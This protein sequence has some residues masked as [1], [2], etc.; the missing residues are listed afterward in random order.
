[1]QMDEESPEL[2]LGS[3]GTRLRHPGT[4]LRS[5]S[6]ESFTTSE[7]DIHSGSDWIGRVLNDQYRLEDRLGGGGMG[8]VYLARDLLAEANQDPDPFVAVKV[9]TAALR[10]DTDATR[11]LQ[12][13][14]RRAQQLSHENIVRVHYFGRDA[15]TYY[16]TMELLRGQSFDQLIRDNRSGFVMHAVMP[17]IE[18]LCRGLAYA[19]KEGIIHS[20][21]KPNNVFLTDN[22]VVKV[23]DFGIAV[24]LR[25]SGATGPETRY[26][27]RRLGALTPGYSAVELYLGL[28]PDPRD[29]I[30]SA[31]C[32]IYELLSGRHPYDHKEAP[33]ALEKKMKPA[34]IGGLTRQQNLALQGALALE[35]NARTPDIDEFLAQL[36]KPEALPPPLLKWAVIGA[37][38]L[39]VVVGAI[40]FIA[41]P[42]GKQSA[43]SEVTASPTLPAEP[44]VVRKHYDVPDPQS[45]VES[46]PAISRR[47]PSALAPAEHPPVSTARDIARPANSQCSELDERWDR[48]SCDAR[49]ACFG[50]RATD[51]LFASKVADP[52]L[53]PMYEAREQMYGLLQKASCSEQSSTRTRE[54]D[55]FRLKFPNY[56]VH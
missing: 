24:P 27:P 21:I 33:R 22:N 47:E 52:D 16:L 10:D 14:A 30:F 31:A 11:G 39:V 46:T 54:Y 49:R 8:E 12:R 35:R 3:T 50:Q 28:D 36:T 18:G 23:L 41:R 1:M 40:W 55:A 51:A 29:D 2:D 42:P 38:S 13:E 32:V 43:N 6:P 5:D 7:P 19:H 17:L 56:P 34:A 9:L 25:Q 37:V 45:A 15:N 20:D 26:N 44:P 4:R 53:L 48:L